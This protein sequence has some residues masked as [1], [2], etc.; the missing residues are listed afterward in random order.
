IDKIH[1]RIEK[2]KYEVFDA[3]PMLDKWRNDW[4]YI[5]KVI[6]VIP[7]PVFRIQTS[8]PSEIIFTSR[9]GN[10]SHT[11]PTVQGPISPINSIILV[12][13][14]LPKN[15]T[16]ALGIADVAPK[17]NKA[18]VHKTRLLKNLLFPMMKI[19]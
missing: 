5:R 14:S 3:S 13:S 11:A 12:F 7:F 18:N 9:K 6:R 15:T 17:Q 8:R 16:L 1:G 10:P 2:R 4:P 19:P